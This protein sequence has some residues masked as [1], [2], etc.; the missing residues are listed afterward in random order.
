MT[1]C[2]HL[3]FS[4]ERVP[5]LRAQRDQQVTGRRLQQSSCLQAAGPA[6]TAGRERDEPIV[7]T[8]GIQCPVIG[9]ST[10]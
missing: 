5:D 2:K 10:I 6:P 7:N 8:S 4:R 1:H 3:A 9:M